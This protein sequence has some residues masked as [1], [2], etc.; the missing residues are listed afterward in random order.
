MRNAIL[1]NDLKHLCLFSGI[2]ERIAL[3][4]RGLVIADSLQLFFLHQR[5]EA[6]GAKRSAHE[7]NDVSG[8]HFKLVLNEVYVA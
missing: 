2:R 1:G 5:I 7:P 8:N 3:V 6:F 4:S